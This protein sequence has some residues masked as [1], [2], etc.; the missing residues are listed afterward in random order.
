[1]T[2]SSRPFTPQLSAPAAPG[3]LITD[4]RSRMTLERLQAE[5]RRH[6]RIAEQTSERNTPEARI[7]IWES[8]HG[9]RL[10]A[11][12]THPVLTAV[13]RATELTLEQVLEEQRQRAAH[14]AAPREVPAWPNTVEP[15]Q[16]PAADSSHQG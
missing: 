6:Q 15:P 4:Y 12:P 10:P 7:R 1:M 8:V 14:P 13:A 11:S 5:E 3:D 2:S 16:A 9:L